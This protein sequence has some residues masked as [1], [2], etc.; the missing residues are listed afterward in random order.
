VKASYRR[1]PIEDSSHRGK[2]K[3]FVAS[4]DFHSFWKT[5]GQNVSEKKKPNSF[6]GY[7]TRQK[8]YSLKIHFNVIS[9]DPRI[10]NREKQQGW[11]R[12]APVSI[13]AF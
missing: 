5:R 8:H 4:L 7:I 1:K 9:L 11:Q 12:E 10:F 6:A 2:I 13:I 3:S